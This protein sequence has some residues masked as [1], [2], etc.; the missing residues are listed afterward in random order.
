[1]LEL[2]DETDS[3]SVGGDTVWVRPPPPAPSKQSGLFSGSG[4]LYFCCK[5]Y[6]CVLR[7]NADNGIGRGHLAG[8]IQMCTNVACCADVTVTEPLLDFLQAHAIGIEQTGAG[9]GSGCAS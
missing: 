2:A 1:M 9:R 5:S 6:L 8:E 7:E 4:L 3:K